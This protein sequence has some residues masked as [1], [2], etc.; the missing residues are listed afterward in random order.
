M[1]MRKRTVVFAFVAGATLVASDPAHAQSEREQCANA[2]DQAQQ[3]RDEGKYRRAREQ[4][5]LCA[6]DVCPGPIKRDCLDWLR[7]LDDVAPSVVFAAKEG[8]KDL[9]DVKVTMDGQPVASSLDGR[10]MP[11]DLGKHVFRFEHNGQTQDAEVVIGAG[12]KGRN[13][14]VTFG[15]ATPPP[16]PPPPAGDKGGDGGSIVLPLVVGGI[17]LAAIGVGAGFGLSGKSAV[18]DLQK[19]KPKCAQSDV[20]SARTKLIVADISFIA[21]AVLIAGAVVLYLV[22]PKVDADARAEK[23]GASSLRLDVGPTTQGTG[24]TAALGGSF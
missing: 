3:L 19:C 1:A 23:T 24:G 9:T 6:R 12:Q 14:S 15:A 16:P 17:G 21:G 7:Q 13:I 8:N 11:V 4:M 10:P 18:D 22:R 5:L 20:D 2:A